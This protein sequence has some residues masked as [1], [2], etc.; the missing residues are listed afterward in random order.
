M[1]PWLV[2]LTLALGAVLMCLPGAAALKD[3]IK[4]RMKLADKYMDENPVD[5]GMEA[6]ARQHMLKMPD[7]KEREQLMKNMQQMDTGKVR[8]ITRQAMVK[9]FTVDE[10]EYLINMYSTHTGKTLM[11]KIGAYSAE[12][13]PQIADVMKD[14]M[15]NNVVFYQEQEKR[16]R[17][18]ELDHVTTEFDKEK[19]PEAIQLPP[20]NQKIKDGVYMGS[21]MKDARPVKD[22]V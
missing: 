1:A 16:A 19:K 5:E 4:N 17:A 18:G 2:H 10:L 20:M 9:H 14:I 7:P 3:T 22:E 11:S 13:Q 6:M 21:S 15:E 8:T 12:I